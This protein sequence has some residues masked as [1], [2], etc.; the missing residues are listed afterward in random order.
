V[1]TSKNIPRLFT[2]QVYKFRGDV[3]LAP[4]KLLTDGEI[5]DADKAITQL[6]LIYKDK[7]ADISWGI[8]YFI[9]NSNRS[10]PYINFTEP[11]DVSRFLSTLQT[12]FP[13]ERW[14]LVVY[15]HENSIDENNRHWDL[16][17]KK[18]R[19]RSEKV[20]T[21]TKRRYNTTGKIRLRHPDEFEIKKRKGITNYSSRALGYILHMLAIM[22]GPIKWT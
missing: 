9:N 18:G 1:V 21:K 14:H 7:K 16:L 11:S 20:S 22:I 15:M 8:D 12:V 4:A 3:I 17:L 6:K 10:N 19:V 2:K 13:A 5:N